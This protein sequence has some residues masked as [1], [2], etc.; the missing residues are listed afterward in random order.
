M[1]ELK[2]NVAKTDCDCFERHVFHCETHK[3]THTRK[4]NVLDSQVRTHAKLYTHTRKN[5]ELDSQ[6]R[7][8]DKLY[9]QEQRTR[10]TSAHTCQIV[11]ASG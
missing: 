1:S 8:H 5:N 4:N 3:H 7:T 2:L 6:V 9:T 10:L 11:D